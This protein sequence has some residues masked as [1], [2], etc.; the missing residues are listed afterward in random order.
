MPSYKN[1][2]L[3]SS[4]GIDTADLIAD[5][6]SDAMSGS[7]RFVEEDQNVYIHDGASWTIRTVGGNVVNLADT[8]SIVWDAGQ[9]FAYSIEIAADRTLANP[10]SLIPGAT[11]TLIVVQGAGGSHVLSY[12]S[13]FYFS[14]G[15]KPTLS[16]AASAVD[17]LQFYT[18]G[19][20]LFLM[21]TST[22]V[23]P[24]IAAP[25]SLTASTDEVGQITLGWTNHAT[26]ATGVRIYRVG[27][28]FEQLVDLS[29]TAVSYI[30]T[31]LDPGQ[32]QYHVVAFDATHESSPSND[33]TGE[34]L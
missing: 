9:G 30:D 28:G 17:V 26:N 21:A 5:L 24:F 3:I 12:G 4:D 27:A 6:P 20:Y 19:T 7:M 11:Y 15:S 1:L 16:T 22:N 25:T 13:N 31:P 10:T 2:P 34:A 32:Q 18:D 33:A 29:P 8:S 23:A 14:G